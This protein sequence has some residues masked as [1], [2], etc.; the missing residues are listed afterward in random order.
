MPP[1]LF[2][3]IGA[4]E[5][6]AGAVLVSMGLTFAVGRTAMQRLS[7]GLLF[8]VWFTAINA[9]SFTPFFEGGRGLGVA[10]IGLAVALP[11]SLFAVTLS[12]SGRMR[13]ALGAAPLALLIAVHTVRLFGLNFLILEDAGRLSAPFAPVA[14][15]GDVLVGLAA[16]PVAALLIAGHRAAPRLALAFTLFGIADLVA[17][18]SLGVTSAPD[19]PLRLFL[20]QSVPTLTRLPWLLVPAFLVPTFLIAHLAALVRLGWLGARKRRS[21]AR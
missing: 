20:G 11:V 16:L 6:S 19:S 18:V 3:Q 8:L 4:I 2:D 1:V 17:A 5:L 12:V 13:A 14:G 7:L 9:L 15:W 21:A 10:A